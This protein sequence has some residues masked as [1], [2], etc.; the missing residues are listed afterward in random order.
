MNEEKNVTVTITTSTIFKALLLLVLLYVLYLVRDVVLVVLTAAVIATAIEPGTKWLVRHKI[1]RVF[2]AILIY[3][4]VGILVA[5]IFYLLVPPLLIETSG[6]LNNTPQYIKVA[7]LWA[8]L[9]NVTVFNIPTTISVNSLVG[10]LSGIAAGFSGGLFATASSFVGGVFSLVLIVVISFYLVVK[11]DG[12][13]QLLQV[14]VPLKNEEYI[15]NL[16]RRTQ[17]KIGRW[18]Q[19]QIFIQLIIGILIFFGLLVLGI[20]HPLLFAVLAFAFEIIPVFGMTMAAL[21]AILI[22]LVSG[23][24]GL[25]ILVAVMYF[26]VQQFESNL[27]YPMVVKQVIGIPPLLVI[28]ALIVGGELAGFL[29]V[30]L[31]VPVSVALMEMIN[32]IDKRKVEAR[33]HR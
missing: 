31:S 16:W 14:V 4:F 9:Q 22:A 7:E 28:I 25:A 27:I 1:P 24:W 11:E 33:S 8:P 13:E 12:I 23:G 19:G 18:M 29:G 6:L 2:S 21:P 30:I 20:P 5:G 32:D 15:V 3:L 26:V 10:D 17:I